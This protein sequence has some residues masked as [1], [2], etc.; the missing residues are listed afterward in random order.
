MPNGISAKKGFYKVVFL[1]SDGWLQAFY[2]LCF[3]YFFMLIIQ[4]LNL[5][6]YAYHGVYEEEKKTGAC[7][8]V[9]V[10]L[11]YTEKKIPVLLLSETINYV[12]VYEVVKKHMQQPQQLLETVATLLAEDLLVTFSV[13][14]K[15]DVTIVKK[16]PPIVGFEGSVAVNFTTQRK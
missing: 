2:T 8:E 15:A 9:T 10:L 12:S 7:F 3:F 5:P 16:H 11:S 6:F 14:E 4:L 1:V 13:A